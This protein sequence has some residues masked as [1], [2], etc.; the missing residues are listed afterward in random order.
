MKIFNAILKLIWFAFPAFCGYWIMQLTGESNGIRWL[1]ALVI[2]YLAA[3]W[4][5]IN[6]IYRATKKEESK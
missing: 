2:F 6:E 5:R 1:A 4:D 3:I